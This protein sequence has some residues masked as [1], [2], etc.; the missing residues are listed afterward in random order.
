MS[1]SV[2]RT[3]QGEIMYLWQWRHRELVLPTSDIAPPPPGAMSTSHHTSVSSTIVV[4]DAD[5]N[6]PQD[7]INPLP[8][9]GRGFN[10][11]VQ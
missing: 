6:L 4:F 5:N 7:Y 8:K 11:W 9:M 3:M 10:I 2:E 1:H